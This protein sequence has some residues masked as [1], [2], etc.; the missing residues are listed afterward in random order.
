M[1]EPLAAAALGG[2]AIDKAQSAIGKWV[3]A[4]LTIRAEIAL[5]DRVLRQGRPAKDQQTE[6]AA[7]IKAAVDLTATEQFPGEERLQ[8]MFKD[9]LLAGSGQE[10]PLVNG[11]DLT[12]ITD[13]VFEWV[14]DNDLLPK[15][16]PGNE[17]RDAHPYLAL[18]CRNIIAQFGFRAENNGAKNTILYPRWH[19]FWTTELFSTAVAQTQESAPGIDQ[20]SPWPR[21][22]GQLPQSATA[23]LERPVDRQLTDA[24]ATGG[25]TVGCQI[26]SGMGGIGKTQIAAHYA[27][28]RWN[29]REVDLLMW[30]NAATRESITT[31][32]AQAGSEFCDADAA[33]SKQAANAFLDWLD[34]SNAPRW[35]IVLDDLTDP[36]DLGGLWPPTNGYG[37]TIVT[38]RRR[39]TAL[40]TP[41]RK[42]IDVGLYTPEQAL[43]YLTDRL[44]R[45][46]LL[47]E[48]AEL[49]A[50]L[51][52]LPLALTQAA[53]YILDQPGATCTIYRTLLA[54][55]TLKL[56]ELSP[57][58]LPDEYPHTVAAALTIA[59][60]HADQ[61]EP[62]GLAS[63]LLALASL[64]DPNGFPAD[65]FTVMPV[66]V[67][68]DE[69]TSESQTDSNTEP[70]QLPTRTVTDALARLH[71]LNLINHDGDSV[72][73]HAL[74]QRT[75]RDQLNDD[76]RSLF[77]HFVASALHQIWPEPENDPARSA[78]LRAN[79]AHLREHAQ[80]AL[81][82]EEAHPLLFLQGHSLGDSGLVDEACRHFDHLHELCMRTLGADHPHTLAARGNL[83]TWRG[84]SGDTAGAVVIY[85]EVLTDLVQVNG[86]EHLHTLT[87]RGNL[88]TMQSEAGD[89]AGALAAFEALLS[90]LLRLVGPN[91]HL[92]L[93]TRA[94]IARCRGEAGDAAGAATAYAELLSDRLRILGPD[95][96]D[97]LAA[98]ANIARW[99]G[100]AGD[101]AGAATAYAELL[102]DRLRILGPDHPDT[103]A[104]RANIARWRG[105]AG[106]AA[107]AATAYAELLSDRLR[108]LGP[109]HPDTLAARA[110]IAR[111]R[112]EA[113]DAAG[114]A[115]AYAELLSDRLR[116]LGPDHPDTLAARANI[117]RW[118]GEAGDATGAATLCADLLPDFLRILGPNHPGTLTVRDNL[119]RWRGEAGDATAAAAL[120]ADLVTDCHRI[121]GPKH[122]HT[123]N[124]GAQLA[125][126]RG[127]A[128]DAATAASLY[129]DL[130]TD[131]LRV[132][133][134]NHPDTLLAH[135]NH[136]RWQGE[137]GDAAGAAIAFDKLLTDFIRVF[138]PDHPHTLTARGNLARW[139]GEDGE[140]EYAAAAYREILSD[141]H[142]VH[143]ADH[144]GTLIARGNLATWRGMAGDAAGALTAFEDLLAD[145]ERVLGPDHPHTLGTRTNLDYWRDMADDEPDSATH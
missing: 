62:L 97:T 49:A 47:A 78:A 129:T 17:D 111:W 139:R 29:D 73:V 44:L 76:Q 131:F 108:I 28:Q 89:I 33:D 102:S 142:R 48:A 15:D 70:L 54:D 81:I 57:E 61:Y 122:P 99:R 59:I 91:H 8:R 51:G 42:R 87:A 107:G 135:A 9:A 137:S 41:T 96:P 118:R 136:A 124:A 50:D 112:G 16:H 138:G 14:L 68:P 2:L 72:R 56:E 85:T 5:R 19:R 143:G 117:A 35:L 67:R 30:V 94:H 55:R 75:R 69:A 63:F 103:L 10:W 82:Q 26:L 71:R 20:S 11:S 123:L 39:D 133:G 114:A 127:E 119:A 22:L 104:A 31:A 23:R 86:H 53:V 60:E 74:V 21:R 18:L 120:Y 134:P 132:F 38:T 45:P 64:L 32:Y 66:T 115:T 52:Y 7:V 1:V 88:A 4:R 12:F 130:L 100:E 90:D 128:G 140:P 80:T 101:A 13:D 79:V 34:S 110:N 109:D 37:R 106:D 40:E 77:A 125:Q 58:L 98:R 95:H 145:F 84:Q 83:A 92:T 105:E 65:L 24:L 121:L 141:L 43:R 36:K 144:P 116:I 113:G 27:R 46:E 3:T 126:M 6:L 93:T 25:T